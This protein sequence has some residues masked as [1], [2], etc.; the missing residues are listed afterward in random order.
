MVPIP[1]SLEVGKQT[2]SKEL[3]HEAVILEGKK[4][5]SDQVASG[6]STGFSV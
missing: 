4:Y 1:G 3:Y 2:Q 5:V 6:S